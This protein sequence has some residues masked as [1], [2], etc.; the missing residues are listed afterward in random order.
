MA[1]K[2]IYGSETGTAEILAEDL[3]DHIAGS[4]ECSYAEL[5][6]VDPAGMSGDDFYVVI[7]SSTGSGDVPMNGVSFLNK[8]TNDKPD[9]SHVHFAVFG[10]GD[11]VFAETYN[12]GSEKIMNALLGC[13]AKMTGERGLFDA[14]SGDLPEDAAMPWFDA[15]TLPA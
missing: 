3:K 7:C 4:H 8:L 12:Q 5:D 1:V 13:G 2:I 15:L 6:S 9:L 14:S 11:M 10:I